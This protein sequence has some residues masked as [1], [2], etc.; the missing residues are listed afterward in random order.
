MPREPI[1]V[2]LVRHGESEW[3]HEG[4]IQGQSDS[5]LS[6]LGM[7]QAQGIRDHF[8][9]LPL[10]A[11]YA[12]SLQRCR[13]IAELLVEGR[14]IPLVYMHGLMERSQGEWEPLL[15]EEANRRYPEAR[16]RLREDA[17]AAPPG[18]ESAI[19][20]WDRLQVAWRRILDRSH[21]AVAV[22]SH[23]GIIS[24]LLGTILGL[25]RATPFAGYPF[26][27]GQ[28]SISRVEVPPRG[29]SVVHSINDT[30]HLR[31]LSG[32]RG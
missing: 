8:A 13:T 30:C 23:S 20:V 4:R 3:N 22:V 31:G 25:P 6:E 32:G 5:L 1:T 10:T 16:Q 7:R 24:M 15:I 19:E 2:Y 18:G 29:G 12:S 28:G 26:F 27:I 14:D 9:G 11:I 21:G 17:K